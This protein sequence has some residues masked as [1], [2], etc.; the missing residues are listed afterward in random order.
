MK[1]S[2]IRILLISE[3]SAYVQTILNAHSGCEKTITLDTAETLSDGLSRFMH[4]GVEAILLH[5]SQQALFEALESV[6]ERGIIL[7]VIALIRSGDEDSWVRAIKEGAH[8]YLFENTVDADSLVCSLRFAA[9]SCK[10]TEYLREASLKFKEHEKSV[11]E[12]ESLKG[13]IDKY[14]SAAH[15]LNQPLT[16]LLGS[17]YL[18]KLDRDDPEKIS[19]HMERI[20]DCGKRISAIVKKIQGMLHEKNKYYLGNASLNNPDQKPVPCVEVSDNSFEDLNNLFRTVQARCNGT[21]I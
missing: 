11:V 18:M 7:P 2:K 3:N 8:N 15:E 6:R 17:I 1:K 9:E 14:G 19:R 21:A 5:L 4:D 12:I 13:I 16:A 20:D 10:I